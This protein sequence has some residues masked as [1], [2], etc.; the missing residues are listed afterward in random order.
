MQVIQNPDAPKIHI[1]P[2]VMP[3]VLPSRTAKEVKPAVHRRR[4]DELP[5]D[6]HPHGHHVH[7]QRQRRQR[8]GQHVGHDVLQRVRVLRRKG[9][10]RREPVVHLMHAPVQP[11]RVQQP[12]G[13]VEEG[14]ARGDADGYVA[15]QFPQ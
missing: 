2:L 14:L 10:R 13:V 11:P 12:V 5:R 7:P 3:I 6:K 9:H 4:L 15:A 8:N 1:K